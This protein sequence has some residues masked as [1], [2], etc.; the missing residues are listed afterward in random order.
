MFL[1]SWF[2]DV[3]YFTASRL[4]PLTVVGL[5]VSVCVGAVGCHL[6]PPTGIVC[7]A[8]EIEVRAVAHVMR[9]LESWGHEHESKKP[10]L[11][12]LKCFFEDVGGTCCCV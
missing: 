7:G 11:G 1:S 6:A 12:V 10:R 3:F 8:C 2:E 9:S 5:R 4:R